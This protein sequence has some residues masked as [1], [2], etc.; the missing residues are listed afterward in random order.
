MNPPF[1]FAAKYSRF[2]NN[3]K[4]KYR[5]YRNPNNTNLVHSA[6]LFCVPYLISMSKY[7]IE[8]VVKSIHATSELVV[9]VVSN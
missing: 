2:T 7:C 9:G 1:F 8:E 6:L 4:Y 5:V 3:S